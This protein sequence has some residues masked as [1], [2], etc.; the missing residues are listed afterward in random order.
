MD[1]VTLAIAAWG[2]VTGTI[3]TTGGILA[4]LRD[5]P[6]LEA[7][8]RI[9]V[10]P[11]G[12]GFTARLVLHVVNNGRQPVALFEAGFSSKWKTEGRWPRR[13]RVPTS[14]ITLADGP[15]LPVRL[16]PGEPVT[17][18]LDLVR[19]RY[20]YLLD[21]APNGFAMDTQ[22][23]LAV[24]RPHLTDDDLKQIYTSTGAQ[25]GAGAP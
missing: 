5:R 12:E 18:T 11:A 22:G 16:D 21:D 8:Q 3:A 7:S 2:A 13:H 23:N 1:E 25:T 10:T 19:P 6:K 15:E 4:L 9:D 20:T 24:A 14:R 17:I